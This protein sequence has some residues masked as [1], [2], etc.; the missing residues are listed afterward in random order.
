MVEGS[1]QNEIWLIGHFEMRIAKTIEKSIPK[2]E[3]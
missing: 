3:E 1:N 2:I